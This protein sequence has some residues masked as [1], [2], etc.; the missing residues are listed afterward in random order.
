[1]E[2][3]KHDTEALLE[4]LEH[5]EESDRWEAAK[6]LPDLDDPCVVPALIAILQGSPDAGARTCAAYALGF[7][8]DMR[9]KPALIAALRDPAN[10]L[11]VRCHAAEALGHLLQ[12][13]RGQ[14]DART[15]LHE[16]LKEEPAELRFWAAFGLGNIGIAEDIP[17][18][19]KLADSDHR[20]VEGWWAVSK[21]AKDSIEHIRERARRY[22]RCGA[23]EEP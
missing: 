1:V 7:A 8:F 16:M 3:D 10:D 21:E 20:V 4:V 14:G 6:V 12:C 9:A 19:Q 13:R 11:D 2:T 18:L 23:T 17:V 5:G 22:T 15:V